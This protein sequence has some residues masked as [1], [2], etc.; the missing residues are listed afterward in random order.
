[1]AEH[2]TC[3]ECDHLY[4]DLDGDLDERMCNKCIDRIYDEGLKRKSNARVKSAM[5]KF[6]EFINW[7][8]GE[9]R[10]P[11]IIRSSTVHY[12]DWDKKK[13]EYVVPPNQRKEEVL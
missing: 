2:W 10:D 6:D 7:I 3:I 13:K 11:N 5:I 9:R 1:M 8:K 12:P 4:D